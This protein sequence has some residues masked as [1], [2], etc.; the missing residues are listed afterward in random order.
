[1]SGG[2]TLTVHARWKVLAISSMRMKS[3]GISAR[4]ARSAGEQAVELSLETV[5]GSVYEVQWA[6]SLDGEWT[7]L[8][9]WVAEVDGETSVTVTIPADAA[10]GFFRLSSPDGE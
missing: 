1:M 7:V 10:S 6:A 5:A 2:A 3:A 8:K 9:S 4:D